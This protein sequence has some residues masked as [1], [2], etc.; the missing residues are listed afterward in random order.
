M[1]GST[2]LNT[3]SG[4]IIKGNKLNGQG[5]HG[6][7]IQYQSDVTIEN[8]E[9]LNSINSINFTAIYAY[10]CLNN[11]KVIRN[12]L[13]DLFRGRGLYLTSCSADLGSEILVANNFIQLGNEANEGYGIELNSSTNINVY[14]N[15][16]N[17]VS[18]NQNSFAFRSNFSN[19]TKILNNVFVNSSEG[20]VYD[21]N[22]GSINVSNF[23][24]LFTEG[25]VL[26]TWDGSNA[27]DINEWRASS[28]LDGNSISIDPIFFSPNDLHVSE[29]DLNGSAF[30][31]AEI[32][33]DI[34]GE[35][36]NS[37][38]PDRGADEFSPIVANDAGIAALSQPS[39][40][41]PFPD[42]ELEIYAVIKNN[43]SDTLNAVVV[44][45]KINNNIKPAIN[46]EGFLF[47]GARDTVLLGSFDFRVGVNHSILAYS[48]SPDGMADGD[49]SN[50]TLF[51]TGLYPGLIG[52]YTIGGQ[53]PDFDS[54]EEAAVAINNGGVLG[55]VTFNVR[56][57]IYE[58]QVS[59]TKIK[60]VS[61]SN[62]ITIQSESLSTNSVTLS[63]GSNTR[64]DNYIIRLDGTD[65][66]IIRHLKFLT[67]HRDYATALELI[68]GSDHNLITDNIFSA[69]INTTDA[70]LRSNS[71]SLD[72]SNTIANNQFTSGGYGVLVQGQGNSLLEKGTEIS[73]NIFLNQRYAAIYARNQEGIYILE[74]NIQTDSDYYN[75][76]GIHCAFCDGDFR[77]IKNKISGSKGNG[78][79]LDRCDSEVDNKGLIGN[80]FIQVGGD[81]LSYGIYSYYRS[82]FNIYYNSVHVN[83]TNPN[84]SVFGNYYGFN[85]NVINNIFSNS[86]GGFAYNSYSSSGIAI[87]D[88]NNLFITG[89][90]L[91]KWNN[92]IAATLSEWKSISG[93]DDNSNGVD[94]LF[95]SISDLH[96]FQ[97]LLDSTGIALS[98]VIDDIDG[99]VRSTSKP[100]VGADEF[101]YVFDDVGIIA[102][103]NPESGC[104]LG[105]ETITVEV[106]NFSGLALSGFNIA[107]Q[108]NGGQPIVEN[109]GTTPINPGTS[110]EYSFITLAD[111]SAEGVYDL[112]AFTLLPDDTYI[113]NDSTILEVES[114]DAPALVNNMIPIEGTS[115]LSTSIAFS[116]NTEDTDAKFDLYI[117]LDG[118]ERPQIPSVSNI[119]TISYL[120]KP[121]FIVWRSV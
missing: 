84:S 13:H 36:R 40:D 10:Q 96:C 94:P 93:K 99:E 81:H 54:F 15:N 71:I 57:G 92:N 56:D 3:E 82:N 18:T 59:L 60:G 6:I 21:K 58:E 23:N 66:I 91:G 7:D 17:I 67:G 121:I 114:I 74:N 27:D 117:W 86:G 79:W 98:E 38:Y 37:N 119:L 102:I 113:N 29:V 45:W 20:R 89:A 9:I 47:P 2:S 19:D 52:E 5:Y 120:Y 78:I 108:I 11:T 80:N 61:L 25:E 62:T 116:W 77:I 41:I 31:L 103:L 75:Y 83:S 42:G 53:Q 72:E 49:T 70:L 4:N 12:N 97:P 100:D 69:E 85:K 50:D 44:Q 43:G 46:W 111:L 64:N 1:R 110:I 30:P 35:L 95:I 105:S 73:G 55:A 112:R 48:E 51:V 65:Y 68:N 76:Y 8:N 63:Y 39:L 107:Y 106:Q 24:V 34:D 22:G 104:N 90:Q 101:D 14:H 26:G 88:H 115:G 28:S 32:T 16:V 109:I 87:S 118:Q 33:V